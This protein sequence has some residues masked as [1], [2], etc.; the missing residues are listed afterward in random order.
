[1]P[2][3]FRGSTVVRTNMVGG[4]LE[5]APLTTCARLSLFPAADVKSTSALG[6]PLQLNPFALHVTHLMPEHKVHAYYGI[7]LLT[8][9]R[10]RALIGSRWF[11]VGNRPQHGGNNG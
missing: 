7:K 11:M 10:L 1:L 4:V 5:H 2:N 8:Y 6:V 9:V 3:I